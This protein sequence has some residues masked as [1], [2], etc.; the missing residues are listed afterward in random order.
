[1]MLF[2]TQDLSTE[3]DVNAGIV[4]LACVAVVAIVVV[5]FVFRNLTLNNMYSHL[6][7]MKRLENEGKAVDP[8]PK[9]GAE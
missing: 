7:R 4:F 9:D 1:M 8:D 5:F 6:E 2:A 3:R